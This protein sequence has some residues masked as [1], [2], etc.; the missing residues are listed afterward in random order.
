MDFESGLVEIDNENE[1]GQLLCQDLRKRKSD[2][3][4]A[5][6]YR[7]YGV[8]NIMTAVKKSE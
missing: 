7:Q 8:S 6:G 4:A 1:K 2:I 3:L 5:L